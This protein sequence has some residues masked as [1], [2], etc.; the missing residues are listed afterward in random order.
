MRMLLNIINNACR[1]QYLIFIPVVNAFIY[2]DAFNVTDKE[3]SATISP[4]FDY[5]IFMNKISNKRINYLL[6]PEHTV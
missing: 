3:Q 1:K 5:K 4:T 6:L 2:L